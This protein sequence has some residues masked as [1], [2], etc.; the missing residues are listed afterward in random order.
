MISFFRRFIGSKFGAVFALLFLGLVAFAFAAGDINRKGGF[1][2]PGTGGA[3]ASVGGSSLSESELQSR[4]QRV[5]EQQRREN[6]GMQIGTFLQMGAVS[7]I[8]N[9]LVAG[10]AITEFSQDQGMYLSKRMIDAQIAAIPAF[11]DASGKFSPDLFRQLL[12]SQGINEQLL[13]TDIARDLTGKQ[14]ILPAGLGVAL[15][16]SLVLP[17]ASL[18]LEAREGRV[19]AIPATAFKPTGVPSDAQLKDFYTRNAE[20]FIVP[21]QRKL[22]YAIV[23]ADRFAGA[24]VPSD[25]EVARFYATNK[26][27]YAARETRSIEQLI[28]PNES[29]ARAVVGGGTSL[30]AAAQK[31]GLSVNS[32]AAKSQTDLA[33]E[34]SVDAARIAF[35]SPQGQITGPVRTAFGWA[36]LRVTAIQKTP[37]RT[38]DQVRGEIVEALRVQ[39]QG[40]LL[41]DFSAKIEDQVADGAT[42][43]EVAKDNG[44]QVATAPALLSNGQ[45]VADRNY[46]VG[47]D[48]APLLKPGFSMDA[49]DDPQMVQIIA[50]KRYAL[51]DVTD[52]I[53]AAAPPLDAVRPAITQMYQLRESAARA[54]TLADSIGAQVA[55]GT[56]LEK[57][58]ADA[59]ARAGISLPP[60]QKGGGRRADL[61]RGD[62]RPPA[63]IA[64]L[65]A[66]AVGTAKVVP[67]SND[68]GYFIVQLDRIQ[69][70]DAATVPGLVDRIRSD[71]ANVVAG[72]YAQQFERGIE[73][74]LN[75]KRNPQA[76]ARVTQ[77]LRRANGGVAP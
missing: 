44:L 70:G 76:V 9:Q 11:H 4:V 36:V 17:Y 48:V 25:A 49:D 28:L 64:T 53:P 61:M 10:L 73:R 42:F 77:E 5:F 34:T 72:E 27:A 14:L 8:Y 74:D 19:A 60:V 63:H 39:K 32:I 21:E 58:V 40:Q 24:S 75:V 54:R 66:M 18:I 23:D 52:I 56:P 20:R 43:D 41:S 71:I 51:L 62:Q 46:K 1:S 35:A 67:I 69:Q 7:Q 31:A 6:P 22:R 13:R 16:D 15:P 37:E 33:A 29:A 57:A 47:D 68:Q 30:A 2:L 65:F 3:A 26:A 55:K 12:S 45:N 59:A 38:L 50:Q